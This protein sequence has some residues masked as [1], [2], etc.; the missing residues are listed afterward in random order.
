MLPQGC[1]ALHLLRRSWLMWQ[2]MRALHSA[3]F[4]L[5]TDGTAFLRRS[6]HLLIH[7][8]SS[9]HLLCC[10]GS[11]NPLLTTSRIRW[12]T[13]KHL[14]LM[15]KKNAK[16]APTGVRTLGPNV[17]VVQDRTAIRNEFSVFFFFLSLQSFWVFVPT[18]TMIRAHGIELKNNIHLS[19]SIN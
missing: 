16:H 2:I 18:R 8:V 10:T 14:P 6:R 17:W 15:E 13:S 11:L 19:K 3:C 7:L 5:M 12:T 1:D 4:L 9:L